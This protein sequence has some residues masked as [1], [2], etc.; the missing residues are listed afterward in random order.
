LHAPGLNKTIL[1]S[2]S[3]SLKDVAHKIKGIEYQSKKANFSEGVE[4]VKKIA[5]CK[6]YFTNSETF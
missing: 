5:E 2:G 1:L 4:L 6:M 3:K